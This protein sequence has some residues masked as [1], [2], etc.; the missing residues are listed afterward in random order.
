[1]SRF[2]SVFLAVAF[3]LGWMAPGAASGSDLIVHGGGKIIVH[4][5]VTITGGNLVLEPAS[6]VEIDVSGQIAATDVTYDGTL[7][8]TDSGGAAV[9]GAIFQLFAAS[10]AYSGSFTSNTLPSLGPDLYWFDTLSED[11]SIAV[12]AGPGAITLGANLIKTSSAQLSGTVL[13]RGFSTSY[14]FEYG[15][16]ANYGNSTPLQSL[17]VSADPLDVTRVI[18]GLA[19]ATTYHYRLLVTS[20]SGSSAG[21]D[22]MMTTAVIPVIFSTVLET[23]PATLIRM[24]GRG[25][26]GTIYEI[27]TSTN[28]EDWDLFDYRTADPGGLFEFTDSV[29]SIPPKRFYR[30]H[31][32]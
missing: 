19:P 6:E 10:G 11:G 8:V 25:E 23:G 16:D 1:M 22:A 29:S 28:L 30:L 3:G 12:G 9:E 7:T 13:R 15:P 32:P 18:S 24:N 20:T 2:N 31:Y 5:Q 17:P 26:P 14:Q 21:G 4:N 27:Q